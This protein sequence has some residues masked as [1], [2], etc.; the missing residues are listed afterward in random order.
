MDESLYTHLDATAVMIFATE[1]VYS[2]T[3]LS[4]YLSIE[5]TATP[6][7]EENK[8]ATRNKPKTRSFI[9]KNKVH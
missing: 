7:S 6:P 5:A 1:P 9:P 8:M 2:L 4:K 3:I